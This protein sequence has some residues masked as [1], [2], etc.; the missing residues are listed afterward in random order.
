MG[1]MNRGGGWRPP[2]GLGG[3]VDEVERQACRGAQGK[4]QCR[5]G[6][7]LGKLG[8]NGVMMMMRKKWL[9]PN[10]DWRE[11]KCGLI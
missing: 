2:E 4:V 7:P 6:R 8:W 1:K 5:I 3:I 10:G 9:P 11:D